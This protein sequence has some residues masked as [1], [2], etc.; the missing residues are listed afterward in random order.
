MQPL[1]SLP[2]FELGSLAAMASQAIASTLFR[3]SDM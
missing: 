2:R 3:H 1:V